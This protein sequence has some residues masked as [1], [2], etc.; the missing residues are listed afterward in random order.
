M[1]NKALG[2]YLNDHLG[3]ATMGGDLAEQLVSHYEGTDREAVMA[4]LAKDIIED[5][6][7]LGGLMER[8]G[9][10]QNPVK[11]VTGWMVEK[12]TRAKFSALGAGG[13]DFGTFMAMET[14]SLGVE[15][16]RSMWA[17]LKA[18]QEQFASM[19]SMDLDELVARA[20]RQRAMVET[21]RLA[22]AP[23][24]LGQQRASVS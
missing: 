2:T 15:G 24:A 18:V 5:R 13:A 12:A 19:A 7:T 9:T 3:G 11:K 1:D 20:E 6:D 16:K 23:Q 17:A 14:L 21:E 22:L 8:L 10:P 4:S